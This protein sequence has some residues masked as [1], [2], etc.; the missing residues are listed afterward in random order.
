VRILVVNAGSTSLKLRLVESDDRVTDSVDL[1]PPGDS[2]TDDLRLFLTA[3]GP[4]DSIGHRVVHGGPKFS[5]PTVI[6]DSV[7][8]ALEETI[9]LAPLHNP[10][11]LAAIDALRRLAPEL[12]A[13]ACFDTAFHSTLESQAAS[14]ALPAAWVDRWGLR[15]YGFHGLSCEWSTGRAAALLGRSVASLRLVICHLGGGASVTAV[16]GGR[17]VDTTMGFTPTEGLVMATRPGDVDPGAIAWLTL[18]GVAPNEL[19]E[20]LEKRSG[21]L[22]L[23]GGSTGDMRALLERRASGDAAAILAVDVY[24]HRLRAKIAAMTAATDGTDTIIFT[25]GVGENASE[26]RKSACEHLGWLGAALDTDAN[27]A[28]ASDDIDISRD[29]SSVRILVIHA[30]EELVVAAG[31][32]SALHRLKVDAGP[33]PDAHL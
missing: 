24:L 31:C 16:A 23:S 21:L 25:A 32:R 2:L 12:P 8:A 1:P 26:I 20:A 6:D 30:R 13:V 14:Y 18:R 4:V 29:G 17:S 19:V 10:P 3:A 33:E 9:D 28:V 11:A 27:D 7:R 5:R 15:R 22:A